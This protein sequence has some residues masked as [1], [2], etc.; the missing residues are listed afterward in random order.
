MYSLFLCIEIILEFNF[1]ALYDSCN[2][3]LVK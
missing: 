2:I 1:D 3:Y